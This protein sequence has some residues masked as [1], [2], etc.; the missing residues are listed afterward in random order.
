MIYYNIQLLKLVFDY[1]KKYLNLK[2]PVGPT[3][4][5]T[6]IVFD[7]PSQCSNAFLHCPLYKGS[8][9]WDTMPANAQKAANVNQFVKIIK[10]RYAVYED[11][12]GV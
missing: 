1:S 11:L 9:I 8:Q 2:I 10:H 3:R 5:G 7:I 12:L 6:K 4:A